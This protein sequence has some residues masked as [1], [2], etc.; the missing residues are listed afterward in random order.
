MAKKVGDSG[1]KFANTCS[2]DMASPRI[3]VASLLVARLARFAR[4]IVRNATTLRVRWR[5]ALAIARDY[6]GNRFALP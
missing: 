2:V 5:Y 4:S 3:L 1:A 6:D